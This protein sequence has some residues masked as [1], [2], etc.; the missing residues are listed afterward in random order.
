MI[1]SLSF[2]HASGGNPGENKQY[3]RIS[4]VCRMATIISNKE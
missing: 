4:D 3:C 2:P 1:K